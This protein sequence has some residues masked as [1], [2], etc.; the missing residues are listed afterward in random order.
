MANVARLICILLIWQLML[1]GGLRREDSLKRGEIQLMDMEEKAAQPRFGQCWTMAI[2]E[3]HWQ[4]MGLNEDVQGR[5]ALKFT[6]CLLNQAG[7][8]TYPCPQSR[9]LDDCMKNVDDKTFTVYTTFFTHTSHMC[10]FLQEHTWQRESEK[11]MGKLMDTSDKVMANTEESVQNQQMMMTNQEITIEKQRQ[12]HEHGEKLEELMQATLKVGGK[13]LEN[14]KLAEDVHQRTWGLV[15]EWFLIIH[16]TILQELAGIYSVGYYTVYVIISY[17]FTTTEQIRP[18][19][20]SLF[21][22]MLLGCS[23]E[24]GMNQ[25]IMLWYHSNVVMN[26]SQH[27][28]EVKIMREQWTWTIRKFILAGASISMLRSWWYYE[29]LNRTN[30]VILKKILDIIQTNQDYPVEISHTIVKEIT[31]ESDDSYD[32]KI[33]DSSWKCSHYS[34]EEDSS[35]AED[36]IIRR[37]LPG[38][39]AR[40]K[41]MLRMANNFIAFNETGDDLGHNVSNNYKIHR[42]HRLDF[43]NT[44]PT[45]RRCKHHQIK[46]C[47]LCKQ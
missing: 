35:S 15:L 20:S 42:L 3:L 12:S 36:E 17:L 23:V 11:T 37:L 6:N 22:L 34:T 4:C 14:V 9:G 33:T 45:T 18:A 7:H 19:R 2:R 10:Q 44:R 16:A 47:V 30:N 41:T 1:V 40:D 5:L 26:F 24:Y 21:L 28:E 46:N 38:R 27:A 29:D 39:I 31:D 25:I 13:L 32:S 8:K 43:T